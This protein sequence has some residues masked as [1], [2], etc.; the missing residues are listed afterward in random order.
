MDEL[1]QM[2]IAN[3]FGFFAIMN[4]LANTAVFLG[5]TGSLDNS[6]KK[7]VAFKS[8]L[9]AFI[10]VVSFGLLGKLIFEVFGITMPALRIT[11]GI[12]V[13]IIGYNMLNGTPSK[14]HHNNTTEDSSDSNP[15]SI[16]ISPLA[17]PLLAGPGTIAT[18]MNFM[19]VGNVEHNIITLIMLGVLCI[20][21][22]FCFV[23]GQ[24][25][26]KKIG[27]NGLIIITKLM[28]LILAIIGTQM[29][30]LGVHSSIKLF[31]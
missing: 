16:A 6:D 19:A 11:G 30:I 22:Y 25:I 21:T 5:L 15:L 17:V 4:P 23:Y 9:V 27:N 18:A 8:L 24:N 7:I 14:M 12:L 10:I 29:F 26:I 13:F 28:G 31:S 2:A 20:I 3:F 1:V